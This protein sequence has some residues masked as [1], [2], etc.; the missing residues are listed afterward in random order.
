MDFWPRDLLSFGWGLLVG[1][2]A[3]FLTGFLKK[4]GEDTW[5]AV[6]KR[7]FPL[8]PEP[9]HVPANFN[10]NQYEQGTFAWVRDDSIHQREIEGYTHFLH[11]NG[12]AKCFRTIPGHREF[13]MRTPH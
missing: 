4:A 5:T 9:I 7:L 12:R 2:V 3:A 13:L 11:P 8:D 10:P 1:G 6:H